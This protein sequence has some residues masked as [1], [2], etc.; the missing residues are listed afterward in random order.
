MLM[1]YFRDLVTLIA[2]DIISIPLQRLYKLNQKFATS[3]R[4]HLRPHKV[5]TYIL[6]RHQQRIQ[7]NPF[8]LS[9]WPSPSVVTQNRVLVL[10]LLIF[11]FC[12]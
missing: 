2:I 10:G 1:C 11:A 4:R 7:T 6:N 8:R 5:Y 3:F 9:V 12:K